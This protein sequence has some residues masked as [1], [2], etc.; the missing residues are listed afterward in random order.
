MMYAYIIAWA[1]MSIIAFAVYAYDKIKAKMGKWRVKE[2][3][4]LLLALLMGAPGALLAMYT[5]RHKTLKPKFTVTVPACLILQAAVFY[6]L[7]L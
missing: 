4:L 1:A 7:I 3:T 6:F 2:N 5:L